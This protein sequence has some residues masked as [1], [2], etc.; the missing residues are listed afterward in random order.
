VALH[1][2]R[3]A[4][5]CG[6]KQKQSVV[7]NRFVSLTHLTFSEASSHLTGNQADPWKTL[8]WKMKSLSCY[9]TKY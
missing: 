1:R 3:V 5:L 4:L 2:I 8:S 9:Y 7:L 6:A